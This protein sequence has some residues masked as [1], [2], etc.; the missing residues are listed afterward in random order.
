MNADALRRWLAEPRTAAYRFPVHAVIDAYQHYGK[1]TVPA[2]WTVLLRC[3]RDRLPEVPDPNELLATLLNILLDKSDGRFDY[4]SYLALPLIPIPDPDDSPQPAHRLL[5]RRDRLHT[6]LLTDLIAF[7]LRALDTTSAP[8]PLQ[9][10]DLALVTKRLRHAVRAAT[11]ALRRLSFVIPDAGSPLANARRLA[12]SVAISQGTSAQQMLRTTM[13]PVSRVH[14]EWMFIRVLQ[15]FELTFG[16]LAVDLAAIIT[17]AHGGQLPTV[18]VRLSF[19][20]ALLRETTPLW[21]LLATMQ[22]AAFHT[23][24]VH[25]D[26]ASAI[27]SRAYKLC[28]SLCRTPDPDRLHSAAYLSVPDVQA[29]ISSGQ[30]TIADL[31]AAIHSDERALAEQP[32]LAD[33]L[34]EFTA[35][36]HQW[37]RTHYRLAVRML[38]TDQRGTGDTPGTPYLLRSRDTP[39]FEGPDATDPSQASR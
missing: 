2:E 34:R 16:L 33:G 26:G 36:V 18:G 6:L 7:E 30:A 27:Q 3:A 8:L 14:D 38:G 37:R 11:P 21:S 24:R 31:L 29:R 25:T 10:P 23:F 32:V 5:A 15:T 4:R 20:A 35:A 17:A 12:A 1:H 28:E 19:A 39:L 13:L 22:P 9:R